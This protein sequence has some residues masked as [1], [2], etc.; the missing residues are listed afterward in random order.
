MTALQ[1]YLV[2]VFVAVAIPQSR[3]AVK[4]IGRAGQYD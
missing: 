1:I 2:I 3:Q 4:K